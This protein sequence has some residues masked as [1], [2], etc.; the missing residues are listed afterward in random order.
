MIYLIARV[1]GLPVIKHANGSI[2]VYSP[3]R[4]YDPVC[5]DRN[6]PFAHAMREHDTDDGY[7]SVVINGLDG[8]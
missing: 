6:N 7:V 4:K 5:A 3:M 1:F 8:Q 2:T